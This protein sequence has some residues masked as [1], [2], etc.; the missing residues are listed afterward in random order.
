MAARLVALE[1]L[2]I[3]MIIALA[4]LVRPLHAADAAR[5]RHGS[6]D[7]YAGEEVAL[8]WAVS[9][10]ATE[11]ATAVVLLIASERF[12]AVSIAGVDPFSHARETLVPPTALKPGGSRFALPRSRFADLPRTEFRFHVAA[13]PGP[14]DAPALVVYYLGVPDTTPEFADEAKLDVYLASRIAK[15]RMEK[16]R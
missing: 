13:T 8:A 3:A 11:S 5:E 14:N 7:L 6:T 2:M 12:G 4:A 9:R 15:A 16:P 1:F 10:G